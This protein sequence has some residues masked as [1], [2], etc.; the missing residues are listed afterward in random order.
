M[1]TTHPI[2]DTT[3]EYLTVA[4]AASLLKVHKSTIWRWIENGQLPAYRVGQR[5]V[6]LKKADLERS[7]TPVGQEK[8]GEQTVPEHEQRVRPLTIKEQ[9]RGL[10]ALKEMQR[11]RAELVAQYGTPTPASWELVNTSRDE[12]TRELMQ[13]LKQ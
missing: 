6:R 5:G 2:I 3:A 4:E 13:N 1:R 9:Q 11:L 8:G 7:L 12:R 10:R